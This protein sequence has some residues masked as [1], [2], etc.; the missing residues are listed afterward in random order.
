MAQVRLEGVSKAYGKVMA[1]DAIDL[2]ID[3]G[4]FTVLLGPSGCGKSTT[5]NLIAGL[6]ELT[7]G[8]IMFDDEPIHQQPPHRR[9]IAMVFQ[10]YALYPNRTV[11]QNI[12]FGLRMQRV[13]R[14]EIDRR[15]S[16]VAEILGLATLLERR[17]RQL[18]GGQQQRV[19]LARAIVRRPRVFLLDEPLSNLDAKLRSDMRVSLKELQQE[20]G[21]TFVYVTHDQGEAMS[22]ADKVVV[23]ND[24]NI[25]QVGGPLDLYRR[26]ANRFV[27]RFV[28][29]PTMNQIDGQIDSKG[30]FHAEGWSYEVGEGHPGAVV[31]GVRAEAVQFER[32]DEGTGRV[33]VVERLGTD[34]IVAA[35]MPFGDIFARAPA[36]T[37]LDTGD[38]VL[39]RIEPGHVHLFSVEDGS[40]LDVDTRAAV[41]KASGA[42]RVAG[43]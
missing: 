27:A 5:L 23:M 2:V 30:V 15:I 20:L 10:S 4:S 8:A 14:A 37:P 22:M 35:S 18:S 13:P 34:S 40:R 26:P 31:L 24:G 39:I 42:V 28:G 7:S 9:D 41:E 25:Q 17:P 21:G 16:D 11:R 43:E 3:D 1:V 29:T 6:E 36:D 38:R 32:S 12:A 33:R 19:A